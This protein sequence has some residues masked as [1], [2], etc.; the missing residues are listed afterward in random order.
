MCCRPCWESGELVHL[1]GTVHV[2]RDPD[3]NAVLETA[4]AGGADCVVSEDKDV[5]AAEVAEYLAA[6]GI[7]V[8][9]IRQFLEE[10]GQP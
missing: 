1:A 7:R 5:R 3:D 4:E 2:C 10:L 9:T 6:R 8:L